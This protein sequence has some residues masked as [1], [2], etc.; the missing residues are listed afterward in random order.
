ME[1]QITVEQILPAQSFVSRKDGKEYKRFSFLG[2]T[3]GQYPHKIC[4]TCL[5]EDRWHGFGV[6]QGGRYA[7]SF[8][9]QSRE[10]NGKWFTQCDVWKMQPLDGVRQAPA[11]QVSQQAQPQVARVAPQQAQSTQS[12]DTDD[13]L[14]F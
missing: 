11:Q 9:V 4:F 6:R 14:P 5:G 2:V 3:D 7:V 12:G 1:I 13:G 10:W 8:D